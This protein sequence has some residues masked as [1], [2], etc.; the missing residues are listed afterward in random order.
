MAQDSG[1]MT[2]Y[3]GG[4]TESKASVISTHRTKTD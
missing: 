2:E 3:M 1:F 4:H